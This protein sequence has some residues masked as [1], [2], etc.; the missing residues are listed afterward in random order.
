ML[1][2]GNKGKVFGPY[3]PTP[4][5][6]ETFRHLQSEFTKALVLAH[7]DYERPICLEMDASKYAIVGIITQHLATPT[8]AG[9]EGGRVKNR[10]RPLIAF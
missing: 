4:E 7:F 2:G 9:E 6:K 1:K 8:A 3:E 10:D 5:M